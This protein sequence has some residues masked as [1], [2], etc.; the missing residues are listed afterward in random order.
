MVKYFNVKIKKDIQDKLLRSLE[1]ELLHQTGAYLKDDVEA[2]LKGLRWKALG[3]VRY[4]EK[5]YA[6][7]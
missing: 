7:N 3:L 4:R 5:R 2:V 1:R 6:N